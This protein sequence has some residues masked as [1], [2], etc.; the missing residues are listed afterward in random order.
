[1]KLRK[2]F[3]RGIIDIGP[4]VTH[5][6]SQIAL[7]SDEALDYLW[8]Y[9]KNHGI[10][11][12]CIPALAASLLLS[13]KNSDEDTSVVLKP[14]RAPASEPQQKSLPSSLPFQRTLQDESRLLPYYMTLSCNIWG[15]RALL[16]GF[17][18]D[19]A[20][21]CNLVSPWMQPVLRRD[22]HEAQP[23]LRNGSH[24]KETVRS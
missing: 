14:S 9:C 4:S 11:S 1:M 15:M 8:E 16:C 20:V 22:Q 3:I 13:W 23:R 2:T 7:S 18:F 5:K 19:P 6:Q 12:Q 21:S 10:S 24:R 17:F